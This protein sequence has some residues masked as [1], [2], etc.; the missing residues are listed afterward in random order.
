MANQTIYPYGT[1]GELP[2]SIGLINDLVTGGVDKALTAEQGKVLN[3]KLYDELGGTENVDLNELYVRKGYIDNVSNIWRT[4]AGYHV[5]VYVEGCANVII[6]TNSSEYEGIVAFLTSQVASGTASYAAGEG[7]MIISPGVTKTLSVPSDAKYLYIVYGAST[8]Y[9]QKPNYVKLVSGG[10]LDKKLDNFTEIASYSVEDFN[11]PGILLKTDGTIQ[12]N[13]TTKNYRTSDYIPVSSDYTLYYKD[14]FPTAASWTGI[15]VY[16]SSYNLIATP[17][18]ATE[19][20]NN[21]VINF[22]D[23]P[24]ASYIRI[25]TNDNYTD[26][27]TKCVLKKTYNIS[28]IDGISGVLNGETHIQDYGCNTQGTSSHSGASNIIW[29]TSNTPC[30]ESGIV[31]RITGHFDASGTAVIATGFIDQNNYVI[32]GANYNITVPSTGVQEI[33]VENLGIYIKEGEFLFIDY[34]KTCSVKFG[35]NA[36]AT[37]GIS[38]HPD[39]EAEIRSDNV[40]FSFA[41]QVKTEIQDYESLTKSVTKNSFDIESLQETV[42]E[43]DTS[44]IITDEITGI[45][46]RIVVRN[47][48]IVAES[49]LY[50]NVLVLGNSITIHPNTSIWP[51]SNRG[52]A[53]TKQ[54]YDFCSIMQ[55]QMRLKD[56]STTVTRLNISDWERDFTTSLST[57]IGNNLTSNTNLVIIR[58]GENVTDNSVFGNALTNLLTY[59]RGITTARV[60]VTSLFWANT[61]KDEIIKTFADSNRLTYIKINQFGNSSYEESMGHYVYN[62]DYTAISEITNSGVALH[63]SNKGMVAIANEILNSLGYERSSNTYTLQTVTVSG[64]TGQ[65]YVLDN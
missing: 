12:N 10:M 6:Q 15:C 36:S 58:L 29:A 14:V 61:S 22:A 2:S 50:N 65:M 64:T 51:A 13:N 47:G 40:Y 4:N 8:T 43:I 30:Q 57:L 1:N 35:V 38:V 26:C 18:S 46:Y 20:I 39:Y 59:I 45:P 16:D 44:G 28:V 49:A 19:A 33:S 60:V 25:S 5:M 9:E 11:N 27:T 52:M 24:Q 21:G 32:L 34:T 3:T 37:T 23:Y 17:V 56:N 63:P 31:S 42:S 53:A 62:D 55:T 41:W 48:Q 54:E 7:L